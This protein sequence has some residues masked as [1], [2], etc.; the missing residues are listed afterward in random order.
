MPRTTESAALPPP[1]VVRRGEC[2]LDELLSREWL[3]TNGIGAYASSTVIGCNTRRYHGLLVAASLAPVGR[4][5]ALSTVMEQLVAGDAAHDLATNEFAG[6]FDPNGWVNLTE[7]RNDVAPTFVYRLGALELRKR[8]VLAERANAVAVQY[9][10]FG[11][12][13][14]LRLRPLAALRD[15]HRVRRCEGSQIG[16]DVTAD[17]ATVR[18]S[19]FR[20]SLFLRSKDATFAPDPQWWY[21]F[22]YRA[23]FA[24]GQ[25]E[26]EDLYSPGTFTFPLGDG[27]SV[28]FNASLDEPILPEFEPTLR[29]RQARLAALAAAVGEHADETTRRLAVASDAFVVQRSFPANPPSATI[30]AGYHWFADW[31]RDAFIALPGLLL[32]TGRFDLARQ[33]FGT[34]VRYISE[35]MIPNCFDD[36]AA[37]AHYNSI[38]A[39][40]WFV[41]AASRYMDAA[42]DTTFWRDV[43]MP[44]TGDILSAYR[45]GAPFGIRADADGLLTGGS[46]DTQLTWM[47]AKL[48]NEVITPRHGK[49]VEVNA[50]WHSAHCL[51]ADRCKGIDD[52]A[53]A[54][55]ARQADL[56]AAAFVREFWNAGAGCLYDCIHNGH[57]DASIRPNQLFAV[58]LPHSPL[59]REQQ[60]A[61]LSVVTDKLLT[62]R[63][64]RTLS[65][66]DGRYQPRYGGSWESRDRAYHQGTVWA[67]LMGPYVEACLKVDGCTPP[68]VSRAKEL[69]A[70]FDEHLREAGIGQ[71]SEIFD[72]SAPHR[73]NGCIAQAWSVAEILRAKR[74]VAE[75]ERRL[76]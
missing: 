1:I 43:L 57:R 7:F 17:G 13:A 48:G 2:D 14:A 74:L 46:H 20:H 42:H 70:G 49:A 40:L 45:T 6:S 9:T 69:L 65:P 72:G 38:D 59:S 19:A 27:Q 58:S 21:R 28:Q 60:R 5:A 22:H 39:S 33:V 16:F 54:R 52:D 67:W 10:L 75:C 12:P 32:E 44:A 50:L 25:G 4:I 73:S 71:I 53:A 35:G 68:A 41:I 51:L 76:G 61:V 37:S 34:F 3:L 29:R 56:I 31:G 47:D 8:I 23:D 18:D 36:Y 62:P 26:R 55:Y 11:G 30:V 63:G 64:L 15:Y 24:R 66:D